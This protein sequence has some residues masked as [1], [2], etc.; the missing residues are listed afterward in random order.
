MVRFEDTAATQAILKK[1][2]IKAQ[3]QAIGGTSVAI[4]HLTLSAVSGGGVC[5]A[6]KIVLFEAGSG[7]GLQIGVFAGL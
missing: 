1:Q 7:V 3:H 6:T 4:S 2:L 5:K